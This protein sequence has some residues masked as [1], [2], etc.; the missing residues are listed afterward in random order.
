MLQAIYSQ[1]YCAR[2]LNLETYSCCWNTEYNKE[3]GKGGYG[4]RFTTEKS[5]F[6]IHMS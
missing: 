1:W 4:S 6:T 3:G 2:D 5:R